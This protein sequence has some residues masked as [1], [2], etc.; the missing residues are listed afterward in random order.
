MT[1]PSEGAAFRVA[2]GA[3]APGRGARRVSEKEARAHA[4]GAERGR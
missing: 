2:V 4:T 3:G 1:L